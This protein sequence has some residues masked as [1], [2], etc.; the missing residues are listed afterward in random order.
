MNATIKLLIMMLI[1]AAVG[2]YTQDRVTD[3]LR[4]RRR[5]SEVTTEQMT[6]YAIRMHGK[7]GVIKASV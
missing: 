5:R 4:L 2:K 1:V 3:Q 6:R 7:L